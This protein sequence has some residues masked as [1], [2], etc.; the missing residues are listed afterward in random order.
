M[1]ALPRIFTETIVA[2]HGSPGRR[3]LQRLPALIDELCARWGLTRTGGTWHGN[4]GLVLAVDDPTGPAVLKVSWID[5]KTRW[6]AAALRTW[7]GR[8]AVRVLAV[9]DAD[10]ALLLERLDTSRSLLDV[11]VRAAAGIAG[12]LLRTLAVP[13]PAELPRLPDLAVE[14]AE[15]LPARWE[16]LGGPLPRTFLDRATE[17]CTDL[18]GRAGNTLV[19]QDLHYANVLAGGRERWLV[20]DPKVVAGDVEFGVCP[21]L[22]NRADET[23]GGGDLRSRVAMIV[24]A[25]GLDPDLTAAWSFVRAVEYWLWTARSHVPAA[26]A[27][28]V[29]RSVLPR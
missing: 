12:G 10:G 11:P 25:A 28:A 15:L 29:A 19:N 13:A 27:E 23:A 16:Q 4:C 14:W 9:A 6:E 7:G 22:W 26:A 17:L 20:I 21:L 1:D 5:E 2:Q 18:A 24:D 8:G 3:W